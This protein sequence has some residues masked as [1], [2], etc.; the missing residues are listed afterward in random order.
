MTSIRERIASKAV[1]VIKATPTGVRYSEMFRAIEKLCPDV[2]RN[3]VVGALHHFRNHLPKGIVQ[4]GKGLYLFESDQSIPVANGAVT[5]LSEKFK[6]S[7]F[8]QPF[9]D[10]LK[11][12]LEEATH[13]IP[14]GGSS[15]KDKWGTPDVIGIYK[16]K[17]SDIIKFQEEITTA[18]IKIDS[19]QLIVAFGQACA[20]KLFS[21]RVYL[22]VPKAASKADLKR[23]D[24]LAG[25]SGIGLV[26]FD[27]SSPKDPDF[28]IQVRAAKHEPD[29][30]YLN[31][32]LAECESELGL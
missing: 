9:A 10:W 1:E 26:T 22:V 8:Y 23:L 29:Y 30:F 11:D 5:L 12:D 19:N 31:K 3:T 24:A 7:D 2:K 21:H 17:A 18:E 6:E 16:P 14:L 32:V 25:I 15:L 4:P 28:N 13:A 20:Y 27:S